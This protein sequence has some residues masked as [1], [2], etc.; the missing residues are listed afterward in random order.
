MSKLKL[1][2]TNQAKNDITSITDYIAKDNKTAAYALAKYFYEICD[3][4]AQYPDMG[5]ARPDFS[6]KNYKFFTVKKHYIIAYKIESDCIF[7]SR[8]LTAYQDICILL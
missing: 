1:N 5:K 2:I 7:I 4:L 3:N 6:Y 8:V